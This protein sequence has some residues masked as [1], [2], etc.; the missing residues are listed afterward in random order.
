M[1]GINTIKNIA[2][3]SYPFLSI[4]VPMIS[5]LPN[6]KV[7][8]NKY[9]SNNYCHLD[10]KSFEG[11]LACGASCYL[12]HYFLHEVG[13]KTK[14]MYK[15]IGY[16]KYLEDHCYLLYNDEIMIDPTYRQFFSEMI[17]G[18]SEFSKLLFE[19]Y[20]F[21]F[22]GDIQHFRKQYLILNNQH[23]I[24]FKCNL[25]VSLSDFWENSIESTE[26][27]DADKVLK[28][29]YY[30]KKKGESFLQLNHVYKNLNKKIIY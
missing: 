28:C 21:V 5:G 17:N 14:M 15:S 22:V 9:I 18:K 3:K 30:A 16:G 4:F 29:Q 20:P 8:Y 10:E 19:K 23:E 7:L 24:S 25:D 13:I 26:L 27:L 12:L 2:I 6:E 1:I 11:K